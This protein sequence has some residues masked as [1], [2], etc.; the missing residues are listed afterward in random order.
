LCRKKGGKLEQIQF[1]L[2]HESIET[3]ALDTACEQEIA[4]AVNDNL[5][6]DPGHGSRPYIDEGSGSLKA[7]AGISPDN[8]YYR[9]L[10]ALPIPSNP[11]L[12][13][14]ISKSSPKN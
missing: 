12:L 8:R 7:L 6:S 4:V 9:C 5:A 14:P 13:R 1:M 10:S 11:L 2:G 3:T